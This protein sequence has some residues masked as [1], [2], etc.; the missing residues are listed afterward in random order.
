MKLKKVADERKAEGEEAEV[1][2]KIKVKVPL[3]FWN[4]L[5]TI[6]PLQQVVTRSL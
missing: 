2:K 3:K 6:S 4:S 1:E 5:Q